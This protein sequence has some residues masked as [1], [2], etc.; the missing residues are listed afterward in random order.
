MTSLCPQIQEDFSYVPRTAVAKYIEL[1]DICAIHR[2]KGGSS[3]RPLQNRDTNTAPQAAGR[4]ANSGGRSKRASFRGERIETEIVTADLPTGPQAIIT[5][6]DSRS[7]SPIGGRIQP[8]ESIE[9]L[10][11]TIDHNPETES[12]VLQS[13]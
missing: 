6:P 13:N 12:S 2:T 3:S 7:G 5:P 9:E 1:C 8:V 11:L 10:G 4:T